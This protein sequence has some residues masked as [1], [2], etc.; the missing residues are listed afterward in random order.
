LEV[1]RAMAEQIG[2]GLTKAVRALFWLSAICLAFFIVATA[3]DIG[4]CIIAR[5]G[6]GLGEFVGR[7]GAFATV[8]AVPLVLWAMG[9][10]VRSGRITDVM[11]DH[12]RCPHCGYDMRDLPVDPADGATICPECGCAWKLD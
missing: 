9:R 6:A 12:R 7:V 11:L 8:W 4:H 3:V 5:G 1:V 10:S 2:F